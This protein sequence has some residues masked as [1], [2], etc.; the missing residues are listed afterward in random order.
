MKLRVAS[1]VTIVL[2][3]ASVVA[4]ASCIRQ[5]D[6]IVGGPAAGVVALGDLAV[7]GSGP[8]LV[9]VDISD[10]GSPTS[11]ADVALSELTPYQGS[12]CVTPLAGREGLVVVSESCSCSA[13]LLLVDLTEA[14]DPR[15]VSSID[16]WDAADHAIFVGDILWVSSPVPIG[17]IIHPAVTAFDLQDPMNPERLGR[18]VSNSWLID[19]D[20][21][22]DVLAV[23][24]ARGYEGRMV[25]ATFTFS[26]LLI[27]T[28]FLETASVPFLI[29]QVPSCGAGASRSPRWYG[30]AAPGKPFR[31]TVRGRAST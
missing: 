13:H 18:Y 21:E 28:T 9:V 23:L 10:P 17:C 24:E 4:R 11:V 14:D 27:S 16:L 5:T 19:L 6:R 25:G 29:R 12:T 30:S 2:V 8:R 22:G 3:V 31:S 26:R 7:I 20:A 1:T 15:V